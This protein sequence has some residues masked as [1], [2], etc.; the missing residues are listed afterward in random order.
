MNKARLEWVMSGL[1]RY[2]L[3]TGEELFLKTVSSDFDKSQVPT[4]QQ[5]ERLKTLYKEKSQLIPNKRS[6]P[7]SFTK[8][9]FR[10]IRPRK[11]RGKIFR[12]EKTSIWRGAGA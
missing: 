4:V 5:E 9:S 12:A 2:A 7:S 10:K 1:N 6:D 3:T 8:T 11:P